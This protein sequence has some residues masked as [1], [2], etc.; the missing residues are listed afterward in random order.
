MLVELAIVSGAIVGVASGLHCVGNCGA[1][2]SSLAIVRPDQARSSLTIAQSFLA[3]H[4]GRV[5]VYAALGAT[6]GAT[7]SSLGA[8]ARFADFRTPL[9]AVASAVLIWTGASIAGWVPPVVGPDR[10]FAGL[11]A[12][13]RRHSPIQSSRIAAGVAWGCAPCAMVYSALLNAALTGS[14]LGGGL[15]MLGFGLATTPPLVLVGVGQLA[16]HRRLRRPQTRRVLRMV[17]GAILIAVAVANLMRSPAA[18]GF[19]LAN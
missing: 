17:I 16:V 5:G 13:M 1:I 19:C 3:P 18:M 11:A 6:V 14:A 2:A 15:F 4:I 10:L 7:L 8:I 9:L 12:R